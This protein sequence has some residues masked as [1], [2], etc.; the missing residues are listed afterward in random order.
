MFDRLPAEQQALL[1][2]LRSDPSLYGVLR[3]R[4]SSGLAFKSVCR[5]TALI[6]L[7]LGQ[8]GML[9]AYLHAGTDLESQD[10]I[11]HLI[12]DRVLEIEIGARFISGPEACAALGREVTTPPMVMGTIA[13]LSLD[14]LRY[15]QALELT[16]AATVSARMYFYNRLPCD[17]RWKRRFPTRGAVATHLGLTQNG[18]PGREQER[19]WTK[20]SP[21]PTNDGWLIWRSRR[22]RPREETS[23]FKLYVSPGCDHVGEAFRFTVKSA[24]QAGA[25]AV[26]IGAD[27]YGLLRPDKIV[28]YF[29]NR[30][31]LRDAAE[32][33]RSE[34]RGCAPHGV[35]FTAELGGEGLLSWGLDPPPQNEPLPWQERESW[36]L[37]VTN[38]LATALLAAKAGG[39][40]AMEPWQFALERLRLEGVDTETW[41]PTNAIE[42]TR[43]R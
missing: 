38:R 14:A 17:A 30:D 29:G 11:A 13:R 22:N 2:A 32:R 8:P 35:P 3:P 12:F 43:N 9:P 26:K 24:A 18:S 37:W 4:D 1:S 6:Y 7:T 31:A 28:A 20:A 5:D 19:H 39:V 33:L 42:K 21:Q 27:V 23:T 41:M 10:A 34:L 40:P 16:D 36:R 15:G 25:H